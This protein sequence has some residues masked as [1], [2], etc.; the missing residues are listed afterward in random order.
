MGPL[1]FI[2]G[3]FFKECS[4]SRESSRARVNFGE[5]MK[6]GPMYGYE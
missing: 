3:A 6:N 2:G 4:A 5:E 1:D